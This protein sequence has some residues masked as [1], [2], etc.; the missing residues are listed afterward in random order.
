VAIPNF[1]LLSILKLRSLTWITVVT[2]SWSFCGVA[3]LSCMSI[4]AVIFDVG[5][6]LVESP[7]VTAMRWAK[8]WD[9]PESALATLFW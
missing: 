7:F 1:D 9:L 2:D 6:V 3:N 5:G 4:E 8:E